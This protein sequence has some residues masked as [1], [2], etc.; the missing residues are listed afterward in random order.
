MGSIGAGMLTCRTCWKPWV[1][2]HPTMPDQE[3]LQDSYPSPEPL[4]DEAKKEM[5]EGPTKNSKDEEEQEVK[6][7]GM[8]AQKHQ[9]LTS[10]Q[11]KLMRKRQT[12]CFCMPPPWGLRLHNLPQHVGEWHRLINREY[13]RAST[14]FHPDKQCSEELFHQLE[15]ARSFLADLAS[16]WA[17]IEGC[18][19]FRNIPNSV[20][21][22]SV[23]S[24]EQNGRLQVVLRHQ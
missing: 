22:L 7:E 20:I 9:S 11:R 17:Q 4:Q 5:K 15:K 19:P 18:L 24:Y 13:R 2:L 21:A 1:W 14:N 3:V 16:S 12:L 8:G 10:T 6:E 23:Q